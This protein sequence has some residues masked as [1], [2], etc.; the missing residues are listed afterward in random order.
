M[1]RHARAPRFAFVEWVGGFL[2]HETNA[3][4][5]KISF[6]STTS[7]TVAVRRVSTAFGSVV[8]QHRRRSFNDPTVG[9]DTPISFETQVSFEPT[10]P[11]VPSI[12]SGR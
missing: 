1:E 12:N 10:P 7:D 8:F 9:N 5:M 4:E 11:S 3:A 2:K 6:L